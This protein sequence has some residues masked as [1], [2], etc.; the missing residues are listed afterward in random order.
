MV[1]ISDSYRPSAPLIII[2]IERLLLFPSLE[3]MFSLSFCVV[4][5]VN[6]ALPVTQNFTCTLL[7]SEPGKYGQIFASMDDPKVLAMSA[8]ELKMPVKKFQAEVVK[9]AV[10]NYL[11]HFMT[12]F[13]VFS[14]YTYII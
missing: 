3:F 13:S 9:M 14:D 6:K 4:K 12:S 1:S 7:L 8:P 11:V 2:S 5:P 10:W